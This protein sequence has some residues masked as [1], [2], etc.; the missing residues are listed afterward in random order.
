MAKTTTKFTGFTDGMAA[1]L[2]SSRGFAL[3]QGFKTFAHKLVPQFATEASE[4]KALA[5]TRFL[6]APWLSTT[7]F[8]LFGYGVISSTRPAVYI[9]GNTT[10]DIVA[11]GWGTPSGGADAA[12]GIRDTRVFFQYKG[13]IYGFAAGTRMWRFGKIDD[14]SGSAWTDTYQS[15]SYTNLADPLHHPADDCAYFPV[16]NKIYRLNNTT[17]SGPEL[18]LPDNMV[19]TSIEADGDFI[20]VACKPKN[21]LGNSWSFQWDRDSS[22]ET[23]TAK[24]DWGRGNLIHI[25]N[26]QGVIIGVMDVFSLSSLGHSAGKIAVKALIGGVVKTVAEYETSGLCFFE[27][28]KFVADDKLHFPFELYRDGS[29]IHG[30]Y[31]VDARGQLRVEISEPETDAGTAGL[32]YQGIYRTGEYWWIAHSNDGSVNRTND[33]A[34]YGT[35]I[36]ETNI[37]SSPT[38]QKLVGATIPCE[39]LPSNA[40]ITLKWRPVGTASWTNMTPTIAVAAGQTA[41]H[42]LKDTNGKPPSGIELQYRIESSGGA[43]I[44]ATEN[45]PVVFVH[46]TDDQKAYG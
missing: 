45:N 43:V 23:V 13:Y 44:V 46:E 6:Y 27:A 17:W 18:T 32:R 36:I 26:L 4:S 28:N 9:K 31:S 33:Q 40:S 22:F 30:I 42:F 15:I 20:Q 41:I 24:A 12:S 21:G 1:D 19:I 35:G 8:A 38:V 2:R 29:Y 10:G 5:I 25:A 11:D 7:S 34:V 16:D 37:I 14:I 39:P 3:I